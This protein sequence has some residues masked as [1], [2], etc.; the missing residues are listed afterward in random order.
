MFSFRDQLE[1]TIRVTYKEEVINCSTTLDVW[2]ENGLPRSNLN[3]EHT[4]SVHLHRQDWRIMGQSSLRANKNERMKSKREER[5]WTFNWFIT[6]KPVITQIW[7]Y[8]D[9]HN[10]ISH[11]R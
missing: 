11:D 8:G 4:L 1:I 7:T 5:Y 3:R 6:M 10:T 9:F 2:K